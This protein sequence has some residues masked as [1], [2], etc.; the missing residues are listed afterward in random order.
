MI[1][2][3]FILIV[4]NQYFPHFQEPER[5]GTDKDVDAL[6]SVFTQLGFKIEIRHN[7][8]GNVSM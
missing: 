5:R 7:L 6:K 8:T 3:G 2:R 4:N 1:H